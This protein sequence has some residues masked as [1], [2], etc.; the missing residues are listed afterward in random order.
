M[1]L[2]DEDMV[3]LRGDVQSS[4]IAVIDAVSSARRVSRMALVRKIL[5]D[6]ALKTTRE[7][8]LVQ[9]VTRGN[10]V[11]PATDWLDTET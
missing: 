11:P 2:K 6:W 3:E 10:P 5:H 8:T 9:N 1:A 7:A 4:V